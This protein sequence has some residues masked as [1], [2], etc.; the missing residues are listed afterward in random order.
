MKLIG[1]ADMNISLF[2]KKKL[3]DD[4]NQLLAFTLVENK[5]CTE[6]MTVCKKDDRPPHQKI[7]VVLQARSRFIV[8][9][10]TLKKSLKC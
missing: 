10:Y 6:K 3:T 8:R 1:D 9:H 2:S 7:R 5:Y 4:L